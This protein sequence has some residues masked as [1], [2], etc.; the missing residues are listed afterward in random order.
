KPNRNFG[1]LV[2]SSEFNWQQKGKPKKVKENL[3]RQF[4][5]ARIL[6]RHIFIWEQPWPRKESRTRRWPSFA[7]FYNLTRRTVR[8][9]NK[10]KPSNPQANATDTL[11]R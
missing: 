3:R 11:S 4:I 1:R 10:L 6:S 5:I 8:R 2:T 7:Q 9:G